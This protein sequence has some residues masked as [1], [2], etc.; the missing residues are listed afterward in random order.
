MM[1]A[2]I[3][4]AP[5]TTPT[6]ISRLLPQ[7][8]SRRAT[9]TLGEVDEKDGALLRGRSWMLKPAWARPARGFSPIVRELAAS[10][11]VRLNQCNTRSTFVHMPSSN[12]VPA[13]GPREGHPGRRLPEGSVRQWRDGG[14]DC[15][16]EA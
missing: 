2:W 8:P 10:A 15:D 7:G 14:H 5:R 11:A 13:P 16:E 1:G 4:L 12:L 3:D 9:D 6:S